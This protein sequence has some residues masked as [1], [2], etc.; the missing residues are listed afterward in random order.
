VIHG[1][2][3]CKRYLQSLRIATKK[4]FWPKEIFHRSNPF[5][6]AVMEFEQIERKR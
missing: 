2:E 6:P 1:L 3:E 5:R 4:P